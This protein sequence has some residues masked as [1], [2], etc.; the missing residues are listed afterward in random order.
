MHSIQGAGLL[1]NKGGDMKYVDVLLQEVVVTENGSTK[2]SCPGLVLISWFPPG[3]VQAVNPGG[4]RVTLQDSVPISFS[5][6]REQFEMRPA[7]TGNSWI[8]VQV[9]SMTDFG[10]LGKLMGE[11]LGLAKQNWP[12]PIGSSLFDGISDDI[13]KGAPQVIARGRTDVFSAES[14]PSVIAI[15]LE[16]PNDV[17]GD[18]GS[19]QDDTSGLPT[20]APAERPVLLPKGSKNGT[21]VLKLAAV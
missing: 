13:K 17:L 3:N 11:I 21:V 8:E 6:Y 9:V 4:R 1:N 20:D 14:I 19:Q 15:E 7:V 16:T 12:F 18:M 10:L 5:D 2:K